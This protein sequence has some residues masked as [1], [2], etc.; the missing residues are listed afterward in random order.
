MTSSPSHPSDSSHLSHASQ[1]LGAPSPNPI[2]RGWPN[3]PGAGSAKP[4]AISQLPTSGDDVIPAFDHWLPVR[5]PR[6]HNPWR[7]Y[8]QPLRLSPLATCH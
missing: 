8:D 3:G 7:T 1:A 2:G 5:G 6:R 4:S